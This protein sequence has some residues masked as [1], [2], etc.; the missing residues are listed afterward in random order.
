LRA[1]A[2]TT[3]VLVSACVGEVQEVEVPRPVPAGPTVVPVRMIELPLPPT[4]VAYDCDDDTGFVA[5]IRHASASASAVVFLESG[6]HELVGEPVETGT[7]YSDGS[8]TLWSNDVK[9]LIREDG[10]TRKCV[11]NRR[12]SI[13]ESAKLAGN[14]FWATGNEPGWTLTIGRDEIVY[15]T[16]Y[17]KERHTAPTPLPEVDGAAGTTVYRADAGGRALSVTLTGQPC[18]DSMS[19][20]SFDTT[21][22]VSIDGRAQRGCG[23]ALH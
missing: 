6:T 5:E 20:E 4:V 9:T 17:G 12:R 3:L 14:D 18:V 13:R 11:A 22:M 1:I 23:V 10:K 15:V 19:G 7:R 2:V 21:V 8:I 16:A